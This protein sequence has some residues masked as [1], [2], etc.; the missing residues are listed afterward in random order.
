MDKN[1]QLFNSIDNDS[2]NVTS[3]Y[4]KYQSFEQFLVDFA[5]ESIVELSKLNSTLEHAKNL[6]IALEALE[7]KPRQ[8]VLTQ[9]RKTAF[10]ENSQSQVKIS[11]KTHDELKLA[12]CLLK[13]LKKVD[14]ITATHRHRIKQFTQSF[15][16]TPIP[17]FFIQD[18]HINEDLDEYRIKIKKLEKIIAEFNASQI[19]QYKDEKH[20]GVVS[21][22]SAEID[23]ALDLQELEN[24]A[25]DFQ[26]YVTTK[27]SIYKTLK[28][29]KSSLTTFGQTRNEFI[30]QFCQLIES[31]KVSD[32][33]SAM[34]IIKNLHG[35]ETAVELNAD[36]E[37]LSLGLAF[38]K[39]GNYSKTQVLIKDMYNEY[40]K[41]FI[42]LKKNYI[43][44]V[45]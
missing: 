44:G 5:R 27:S 29:H 10:M 1:E 43:F 15:L 37:L 35:Q 14:E 9:L 32:L 24:E 7:K 34:R 41:D 20:I 23:D 19:Q 13:Q 39:T 17:L 33:L 31:L 45:V 36:E 18:Y 22:F 21:F 4:S 38:N 40:I 28:N 26:Q 8:S 6:K 30:K 11:I 12:S 3:D 42:L 16:D 2:K 25:K